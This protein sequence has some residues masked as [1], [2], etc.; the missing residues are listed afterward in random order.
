[1][2]ARFLDYSIRQ[3]A[4]GM[5]ECAMQP[6]SGTITPG[7]AS[8]AAMPPLH[9]GMLAGRACDHVDCIDLRAKRTALFQRTL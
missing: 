3:I 8:L 5:F 6:E 1:M 4:F 9:L 7:Q 2:N